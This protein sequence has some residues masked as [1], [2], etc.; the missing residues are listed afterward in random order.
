MIMIINSLKKE[1]DEKEQYIEELKKKNIDNNSESK[2][3]TNTGNFQ[4]NKL[5]NLNMSLQ[6][7][8][9]ELIKENSKLK[10]DQNKS[11]TN[12]ELDNQLTILKTEKENLELKNKENIEKI[13]NLNITIDNMSKEIVNFKVKLMKSGSEETG[14]GGKN[15]EELEKKIQEQ[16]SKIESLLKQNIETNKNKIIET[17][18]LK[19][20][21]DNLK[22]ELEE[23]KKK[24]NDNLNTDTKSRTTTEGNIN[25]DLNELKNKNRELEEENIILRG[26]IEN[27]NK[28]GNNELQRENETLKKNYS[29]VMAKLK[30][31]QENIKKA[32]N[33][34]KKVNKLNI[35]LS[36][37]SQL[38]KEMKPTSDKEK[39]LFNKLKGIIEKEEK[40]QNETSP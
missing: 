16:K 28:D 24:L 27:N 30:E 19:K 10:Q 26:Q 36:Y 21:I 1:I 13:N 6:E 37:V 15:V 14:N 33:V 5:K 39:Y 9:D 7:K 32:N 31:G 4:I 23:N 2:V 29:L 20:E 35:C 12:S 25:D 17:S 11:N 8:C 40:E 34:L 18:K 3:I 38:L 22:K